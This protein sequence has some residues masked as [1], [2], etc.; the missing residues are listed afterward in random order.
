MPVRLTL[1]AD[2]FEDLRAQWTRLVWL[3]TSGGLEIVCWVESVQVR[4]TGT[5]DVKQMERAFTKARDTGQ[6]RAL[7]DRAA[8]IGGI[9][10]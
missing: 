8:L 10:G 5:E 1:N 2:S 4:I 9:E 3:A 7:Y 6:D